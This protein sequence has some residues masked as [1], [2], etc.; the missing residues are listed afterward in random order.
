MKKQQIRL[1]IVSTVWVLLPSLLIAQERKE[2]EIVRET[3]T[4]P[5]K[6]Q[7]DTPLCAIYSD[8]S[9]LETELH[10]MHGG[11]LELSAMYAAYHLYIEKALRRIRLRGKVAYDFN[12]F[13]NSDVF[14]MIRNYGIVPLSDYSGLLSSQTEHF[15][16]A[17]FHPLS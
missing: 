1:L 3:W 6:S 14:E 4:T 10:R 7:D 16:Y 2:F 13:F 11:E 8:I 12:G 9:F 17:L 5:T 15:H